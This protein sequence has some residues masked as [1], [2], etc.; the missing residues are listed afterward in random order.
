MRKVKGKYYF[1][2]SSWLNHELCYAVSDYPDKDFEFKG[3]I[4]SNGD[5]GFEGRTEAEKLNM[6]GTTHG[7]IIEINGQWYVFYHRLTHRS[8][9]SRQACAEKI[10][11]APDGTIAQVEITSCGLNE[12]PLKAEGNYPAAI[13]CNITNGVMPHGCNSIYK[14]TFP[15]VNNI[16]EDRFI[17]NIDNDTLIGF[18]YFDCKNVTK[19]RL[20]LR[21]ET[22]ENAPVSDAPERVDERSGEFDE[23]IRQKKAKTVN[24]KPRFEIMLKEKGESIGTI[25]LPEEGGD[26]FAWQEVSAEVSVPDGVHALYLKYYGNKDAQLKEIGFN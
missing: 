13:A 17:A 21:P 2:Y 26:A 25:F 10:S 24:E 6:T 11:L 23:K 9:Y 12:G 14:A 18:K 15:N 1:V 8:D 20:T 7:S 4:V 5:I 22:K 3:T 16:G 19:I